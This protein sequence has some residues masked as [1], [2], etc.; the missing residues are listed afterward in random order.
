MIKGQPVK[1]EDFSQFILDYLAFKGKKE[2]TSKQLQG[3]LQLFSMGVFNLSIALD[4]CVKHLNLQ[5]ERLYD[6]EGKLIK[7]EVYDN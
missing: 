5:I 2:P 7:T 3:I 4:D 6:K 1:P